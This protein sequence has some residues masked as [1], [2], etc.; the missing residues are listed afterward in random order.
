MKRIVHALCACWMLA[1]ASAGAASIQAVTEETSYT[2]YQNGEL[3]GPLTYLTQA[4]LGRTGLGYHITV[5]PWARAYDLALAEPNVLIFPIL[6]TPEREHRFKWVGPCVEIRSVLYRRA[7]R[8]DLTLARWQDARAFVVGVVRDD[9]REALLR[10]QGFTRLV[11]SASAQENFRKLV[12]GQVDLIPLA[13][14]DA[15]RFSN[16]SR[17]GEHP[18]APAAPLDQVT[19]QAWYAYSLATPDAVVEQTREALQGLQRDGGMQRLLD[20]GH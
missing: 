16:L 20:L 19:A 13:E 7:D 15:E 9:F 12:N 11:V 5:F 14:A 17:P 1:T 10:G 18:L 8:P 4:L 3:S 2:Y 6:R